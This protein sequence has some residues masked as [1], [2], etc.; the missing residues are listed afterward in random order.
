MSAT[1]SLSSVLDALHAQQ[2]QVPA[3]ERGL[4]KELEEL[5]QRLQMD[6]SLE[7][8]PQFCTRLA[9]LVQD[10]PARS[11]AGQLPALPP[12]LQAGLQQFATT[13][14]G[15]EN[16]TLRALMTQTATL[17]D[18]A[19]VSDIREVSLQAAALP[20][21]MQAGMMVQA[22]AEQLTTRA[23]MT[24]TPTVE[25]PARPQPAQAAP[26]QEAAPQADPA[27][28]P[29]L[30]QNTAPTND[31]GY[32]ESLDNAHADEA[33]AQQTTTQ[34]APEAEPNP[35]DNPAADPG[36]AQ[37]TAPTDDPGYLESLDNAYADQTTTHVDEAATQQQSGPV[38][39][40]AETAPS[41]S[42]TAAPG[43]DQTDTAAAQDGAES[44]AQASSPSAD[45]AEKT[46]PDPATT[47]QADHQARTRE[48]RTADASEKGEPGEFQENSSPQSTQA[49][50]SPAASAPAQSAQQTK[51]QT[52]TPSPVPQ[53]GGGFWG[54]NAFGQAR[55][56]EHDTKRVTKVAVNAQEQG[57]VVTRDI[58]TLRRVG[59][60]LFDEIDKAAT[61]SNTSVEAVIAGTG[62]GGQFAAIG[63]KFKTMLAQNP[64]FK[65]AH[66]TLC[67]SSQK[68]RARANQLEG[69]AQAREKTND[70]VVIDTEKQVAKVG[71]ELDK[72]PGQLP[73]KS[74]LQE[75]GA[76]VQRL[77]D[78]FRDFFRGQQQDRT[79]DAGPAPGR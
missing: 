42:E 58:Q 17:A 36:L 78:K 28:D 19:L 53:S 47:E 70:P 33:T 60:S 71:M 66:D 9:W 75:I 56:A 34:G 14:P 31:P 52:I 3:G 11:G 6:P 57:N 79:R 12:L 55:L 62:P 10:W 15:L 69:E 59:A 26:E 40:I 37:N 46:H 63:Q 72:I 18:R 21:A 20:P 1:L 29:G 7:N 32:L 77:V 35:Q 22:A 5:H 67:L 30:A 68:L 2:Q 76:V 25:A 44:E 24:P 51:A 74:L 41:G 49:A 61:A 65:A 54:L 8:D 48:Q 43:S 73:G 23:G 13:V 50:P 27:I 38:D 39:P 64:E 16:P 45:R 4:E